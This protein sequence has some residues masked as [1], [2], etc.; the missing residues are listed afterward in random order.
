MNKKLR[1]SLLS[2][3]VMLCGTMFGAEVTDVLDNAKIGVSGTSYTET[4]N[5]TVTSNAVYFAQSAGGNESI[6]LRSN[7]NNSATFSGGGRSPPFILLK[8]REKAAKT[9]RT[10]GFPE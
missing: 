8:W 3:L 2:M 5:I 6:Q 4:P 1:F 10:R 7:K 9:N